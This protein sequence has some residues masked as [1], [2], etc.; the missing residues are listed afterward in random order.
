MRRLLAVVLSP[1]ALACASEHTAR[2]SDALEFRAMYA[3]SVCAAWQ[4]CCEPGQQLDGG[5]CVAGSKLRLQLLFSPLVQIGARYEARAA[6]RCI[7]DSTDL[8]LDCIPN[9]ACS[10]ADVYDWTGTGAIGEPPAC[11]DFLPTGRLPLADSCE[12]AR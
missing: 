11:S 6:A 4:D 7:E 10:C 2:P 12:P 5:A 1:W 3:R 8:A 9:L